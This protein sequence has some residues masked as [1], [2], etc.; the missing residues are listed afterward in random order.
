MEGQG[1]A[2]FSYNPN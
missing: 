2:E 1:P